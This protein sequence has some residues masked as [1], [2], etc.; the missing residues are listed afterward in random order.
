MSV[1]IKLDAETH[2]DLATIARVTERSL[3]A[4]CRYYLREICRAHREF[5][6]TPA[7][8]GNAQ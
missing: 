5:A 1:T 2:R 3:S 7:D 4:T 8:S 6:D